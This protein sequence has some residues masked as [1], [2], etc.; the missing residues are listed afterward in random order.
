MKQSKYEKEINDFR[1]EVIVLV[2]KFF[3]D[4]GEI[5]P[6]LFNCIFSEE[7]EKGPLG[8][9]AG[10]DKLMVDDKGKEVVALSLKKMVEEI[11][12]IATAFVSEGWGLIGDMESYG[13]IE[14]YLK[15]DRISNHPK[16]QEII[17]INFETHDSE[18]IV[19]YSIDRSEKKPKL[20][21]KESIDWQIKK[22]NSGLMQNFLTECYIDIEDDEAADLSSL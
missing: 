22:N 7:E 16:K 15:N 12:P 18:A 9:I 19:A 13:E 11:K 1:E 4:A 21:L 3:E 10:F 14:E 17:L 20:K 6:I 8:V 5:R 2:S